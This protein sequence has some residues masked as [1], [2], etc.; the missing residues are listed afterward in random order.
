MT[1]EQ[2]KASKKDKILVVEGNVIFGQQIADRLN[3]EGYEAILVKNGVEALKLLY[4]VLPRLVLMNVILPGYDSYALLKQKMAE[5]LLRKIPVFLL[6]T[7]GLPINMNKIPQ[8]SVAEFVMQFKEDASSIVNRVKTFLGDTTSKTT[9]GSKTTESASGTI[10]GNKKK[11]LWVEDDKLISNILGKKLIAS[12]FELL[13]VVNGEEALRTLSTERP[14]IIILDLLL[15]GMNGLDI[16]QK[17]ES[18]PIYKAVPVMILT[19]LDKQS[20]RD[21][22]KLLGARI[23]LV[24][25]NTS[26]D[27]I[28][29]EIQQYC[30]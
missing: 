11:I 23:F 7:Q 22:A 20:D 16:L 12:G 25:A 6:S 9:V 14:N 29:K 1:V 3:H 17:I 24:K 19:N 5:P 26:L 27:Q 10:N 21:R 15:P 2:S 13:H 8:D 30:S 18:N 28:V 4:N